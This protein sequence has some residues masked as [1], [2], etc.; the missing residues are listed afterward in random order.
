MDKHSV[1]QTMKSCNKLHKNIKNLQ[2][3]AIV[4]TPNDLYGITTEEAS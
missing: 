1:S 4:V 3:E 2:K